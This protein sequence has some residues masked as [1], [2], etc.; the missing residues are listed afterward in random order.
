MPQEG[1]S[2]ALGD[3]DAVKAGFQSRV[4]R[5]SAALLLTLVLIFAIQGAVDFDRG[6]LNQSGDH[7]LNAQ[8]SQ[9]AWRTGM[10]PD[11]LYY[12]PPGVILRVFLSQLGEPAAGLVWAVIILASLAFS[13]RTLVTLTQSADGSRPWLTCVLS[14]LLVS[15]YVQWDI[16]A[17]NYNLVFLA[18]I[19]ASLKSLRAGQMGRA[20][21]WLASSITLKLYSALIVPYWL[22]RRH[23]L[24]V[25]FTIAGLFGYFVLLPIIALGPSSA[26]SLTL[27][28]LDVVRSTAQIGFVHE[29]VAYKTSLRWV[30]STLLGGWGVQSAAPPYWIARCFEWV[31]FG[32]VVFWIARARPAPNGGVPPDRGLVD[33]SLLLMSALLMSPLL[34]PHQG[35]ILLLP[36][37][38]LV[39]YVLQP[40]VPHRGLIAVFLVILPLALKLA[41][42]GLGKAVMMLV[43]IVAF[44]GLL[45]RASGRTLASETPRDT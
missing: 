13:L 14:L 31:W 6:Q 34:Q 9:E 43:S 36:A 23:N 19:L 3:E 20:G 4:E 12:P 5:L 29:Y 16:R 32:F 24:A 1:Q 42:S 37:F 17:I 45:M 41:P 30:T 15:W 7:H 39:V 35:A 28:W 44:S 26:W 40:G 2:E 21:F 27:S 33:A 38:L 11:E 10:Y 25:L 18:L 22:W 8:S